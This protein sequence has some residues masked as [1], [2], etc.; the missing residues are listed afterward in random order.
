MIYRE[1]F[2][3]LHESVKKRY[4]PETFLPPK[5][6]GREVIHRGYI[7]DATFPLRYD[8]IP[9]GKGTSNSGV[10]AY[11]FNDGGRRGVI[12][13]EHRYSPLVSGH[14]TKSKLSFEIF[15]GGS[16]E[17]IDIHRMLVPALTHHNRSHKPDIIEFDESVKDSA[18]DLISRLGDVFE[19]G[20]R[21]NKKII[22]RKLDPKI[23]RVVSHIRK[24][25]NNR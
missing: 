19:L 23:S 18:D 1:V 8:F 5:S 7:K 2:Q 4:S 6:N 21:K 9:D 12:Q 3:S 17:P 16:L 13:I 25:L 22:R 24:K 15:D 10:H 11:Y 14:E 20:E